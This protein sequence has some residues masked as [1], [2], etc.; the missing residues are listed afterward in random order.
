M[1]PAYGN[2]CCCPMPRRRIAWLGSQG[3][4]LAIAK[5]RFPFIFQRRD[6][7]ITRVDLMVAPAAGGTLTPFPVLGLTRPDTTA[8]ALTPP[9][10][11]DSLLATGEACAVPVKSI[12]EQASWKLSL[13]GSQADSAQFRE[14][15]ADLLLLCYYRVRGVATGP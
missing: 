7:E 15:V 5:S 11:I 2:R 14:K 3:E 9:V 1:P 10:P 13:G 8:Y 4:P 12:D 6:L